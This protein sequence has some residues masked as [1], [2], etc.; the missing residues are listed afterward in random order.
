[1][2]EKNNLK[3]RE[4]MKALGYHCQMEKIGI[5][6][7]N[8]LLFI[9]QG[10][11]GIQDKEK[12]YHILD[13][14]QTRGI[15]VGYKPHPRAAL[16]E[17]EELKVKGIEIVDGFSDDTLGVFKQW[18]IICG[19]H[20]SMLV[21]AYLADKP[22]FQIGQKNDLKI[23]FEKI[24]ICPKFYSDNHIEMFLNRYLES[25]EERWNY[26]KD[27]SDYAYLNENYASSVRDFLMQ[28]IKLKKDDIKGL[29]R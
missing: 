11:I 10:N 28:V 16:P 12:I 3:E 15:R 4:R 5:L 22:C 7:N 1:M 6:H 14:C 23:N 2:Y 27:R 8:T 19:W 18:D 13:L 17:L 25:Q 21:E 29:L 20:S 26:F 24:K 9:G